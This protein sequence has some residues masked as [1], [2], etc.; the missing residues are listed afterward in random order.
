M[1]VITSAGEA[2][3][4][5]TVEATPTIGIIDYSRR[6]TDDFGV[7]T[8]VERGFARRLSVRLALPTDTVDSVQQKLVQLRAAPARWVADDQHDWLNVYGFYKDFELDLAVPPLSFCTLTVEGLAETEPGVDAGGNPAPDGSL[9]SL[10][11]L[12]PVV[13]TDAMLAASTV[14]ENDYPQ[15]ASGTTYAAGARVIKAALHRVFESAAAGNIGNDPAGATGKWIDAGPTNRWAMFDQALGTATSSPGSVTVTLSVSGVDAIALLDVV[16]TSVRAQAPGYDRTQLVA[17]GA[18]LFL[19]LPTTNGQITVTVTA[20]GQASVGTLLVGRIV[21]LGL[22]EASPT[23][24]IIDYSRKEVDDFGAVTIVPRAW[25]KRMAVQALIRT[26]A[27]DVV[28]NRIAAVRARPSLWIGDESLGSL[29]VYGF[30][31]DFS[32]TVGENVSRLSV[33]VE[34][35]S[36]AAALLPLFPETLGDL[37]AAAAEKLAAIAAG[38]TKNRIYER[39]FDPA[40]DPSITLVDGDIWVDIFLPVKVIKTRVAGAWTIGGNYTP[41]LADLAETAAVKHFPVGERDRLLTMDNNATFGD[42]LL[43][44][45]ALLNELSPWTTE[46]GVREARAVGETVAW[47]I[48]KTAGAGYVLAHSGFR[49]LP[50]VGDKLFPSFLGTGLVGHSIQLVVNFYAAS[51]AHLWEYVDT[52]TLTTPGEKRLSRG[53]PRPAGAALFLFRAYGFENGVVGTIKLGDFRMAATEAAATVG[54]DIPTSGASNIKKPGG[55]FYTRAELDNADQRFDIIVPGFGKPEPNATVG[56]PAGTSVAGVLA[57]NVASGAQKATAGLDGVGDVARPIPAAIRTSSNILSRA[58]GGTYAGELDAERTAG[59]SLNLLTDRT[60]ANIDE[61]ATKKWAGETGATVGAPTGTNVAGVLA[62]TVASGAQRATTGLDAAGDVA[63]PIPAAIRTSSDILGRTGG[64]TYTGELDAE[65]TAGKSLTLLTDRTADNL[66]ESVTRKWAGESGA[67]VTAGKSLAVLT[68]RTADNI[69]E[70]VTKKWAGETGA[71]VTAGKSLAV[72]ADR[73]AANIAET[74]TQRWAGETGATIGAKLGIN[75]KLSDNSL[76]TDAA[77]L[78]SQQRFDLIVA[79]FGKPADNAGVILDTR[80]A[81]EPPSYYY[82]LGRGERQE[83]KNANF[84]G[85]GSSSFGE[86]STITQWHD[87]SGGPVK[88]KLTDSSGAIFERVST[89]STTW[90]AWGRNFNSIY[91]PRIGSDVADAGGAILPT[92]RLDNNEQQFSQVLGSIA[93]ADTRITGKS[94]ANLDSPANTKLGGIAEGADVTASNQAASVANQTRFATATTIDASATDVVVSM[95]DLD[96]TAAFKRLPTGERDRLLG[97][98]TGAN[99]TET[100]VSADTVKVNG[101]AASTVASGAGRALLGMGPTGSLL[102]GVTPTDNLVETPDRQFVPATQ[103]SKLATVSANAG[104]T[105][106]LLPIGTDAVKYEGNDFTRLRPTA[107]DYQS[108]IRGEIVNGPC[109]ALCD[110]APVSAFAFVWLDASPTNT[111]PFAATVRAILIYNYSTGYIDT[112]INGVSQGAGNAGQVLGQLVCRFDGTKVETV[113]GGVPRKVGALTS[114]AP[115]YPKWSLHDPATLTNLQAGAYTDRNWNALGNVPVEL[116]DGRVG[117]TLDAGGL[118]KDA[119]KF[120]TAGETVA[121]I[122][123]RTS[124]LNTSGRARD[125]LALPTSAS[126]GV[127]STS[128][129]AITAADAGNGTATISVPAHSRGVPGETGEIS[130]AYAAGTLPGAALNT[131]YLVYTDDPGLA[132][133]NVAYQATT[134]PSDLNRADRAL[135]GNIVTPAAGGGTASGGSGGGT[136]TGGGTGGGGGIVP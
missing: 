126:I 4:L 116:T 129:V 132:G 65:K 119:A 135:V 33:T 72:L 54:A 103:K 125:A 85:S 41:T 6:V 84:S 35:L 87:I 102:P 117:A 7:T 1:K 38:A 128:T 9:S 104:R 27:V 40:G 55:G 71:D 115:L 66:A 101:T 37:D 91:K 76:A 106:T 26:D 123:G 39:T 73:T 57:E 93:L 82:A 56:A 2:I 11:L 58:G 45:G 17:S 74:A 70:T 30:F 109:Y 133:G 64:G 61:T 110:V 8:V 78:N 50:V 114:S 67:D 131:S 53:V 127:R 75:L 83:F 134:N 81:D 88:Q 96:E 97:M 98:E 51:G 130:V 86:L 89:G 13:V 49:A 113:L 10:R 3:D 68:G 79:G 42:N 21:G 90:G 111:D 112:I 60:A 31:K 121:N 118:V 22:T 95:A 5:G 124:R 19:D 12:Q 25:A 20:T 23:A 18:A 63:R 24:G 105:L 14:P 136:Y 62:Q 28:A 48:A 80:A 120:G 16:A 100:R 69:T 46:N 36:K 94:L 107:Y 59:K 32:I 47:W 92:G 99:N 122:R 52:V 15:W 108:T 34:G 43:A 77:V 44:N 29:T